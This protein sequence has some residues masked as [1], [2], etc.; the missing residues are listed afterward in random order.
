M[1]KTLLEVLHE[2]GKV[3]ID[4]RNVPLNCIFFGITGENFNGNKFA[5][6]ALEKGAS[7]VVID[8]EEYYIDNGNYVLVAD[9]LITLQKLA[10]EYRDGLNVKVIGITGTNG[11][12]TTKELLYNVLSSQYKTYCTQGNF[13]NHIG[14]PLSLVAIPKDAEFA[15]I[16]MGANHEGEIRDLCAIANP[17]FG[18]ITNIGKAHLEGFGSEEVILRTK[19]ELYDYVDS[20]RGVCFLNNEDNLLSTKYQS[21]RMVRYGSL[22]KNDVIGL[23]VNNGFYENIEV[24]IKE[25]KFLVE[26]QLFGKYNFLNILAAVT[27]GHY[28][29]VTK[30]NISKAI[31]HYSPKNNRSQVITLDSLTI[32]MDAYNANPS[33]MKAAITS[34]RNLDGRR[35]FFILGDMHELGSESENE[36][37]VVVD[38]L[39]SLGLK[40]G[41]LVGMEFMKTTNKFLAIENIDQLKDKINKSDLKNTTILVKGSRKMGLERV[42]EFLT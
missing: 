6:D 23:S 36:H 27:V 30:D 41:V 13:N 38:L 16:E 34:L 5:K 26:S 12:T 1:N 24:L 3:S 28:F 22:P 32:V 9:A 8:D 15:I 37:Q 33:S 29:D 21:A 4:S 17:D 20:K 31:S 42:L 25:Q 35:K 11:K 39:V 10:R 14:V 40:E 18:L 7:L 19:S 2:V